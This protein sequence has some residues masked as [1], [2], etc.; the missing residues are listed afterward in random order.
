MPLFFFRFLASFYG[1]MKS[2]SSGFYFNWGM[3]YARWGQPTKAMYYLNRAAKLNS[4]GAQ[5]YYQRGLLFIAMGQPAAAIADFNTAIDTNPRYMEAYL[6]RSMMHTMTG[7]QNAALCFLLLA[8]AY[9]ASVEKKQWLAGLALGL[10]LFKP[11]YAVPVLGLL[12]LRKQFV[13]LGV[14]AVLGCGHYVIGALACGWDWP[15]K[16]ADKLGGYYRAAED[17]TNSATHM[18]FMEVLDYSVIQPLGRDGAVG[19]LLHLSGY[20]AL[21]L[22]VLYLIFVWRDAD[23]KREDFGLYWALVTSAALLLSLH[24]QY[25]DGALLL[26]PVLLILAVVSV[27]FRP[28]Q[29]MLPGFAGDVFGSGAVGL[30]WLASAMGVGATI[31]AVWIALRGRVGGLT[32]A[33]IA[34]F[35]LLSVATLG[36][37][38][39]PVLWIAVIFSALSGFALNT[40]STGTQALV[41]YAV[42]DSYRGRVMGLYTLIYRGT[43]AI[44]ALALGA[45]VAGAPVANAAAAP[46]RSPRARAWGRPS[47]GRRWNSSPVW[48]SRRAS[49][50]GCGAWWRR[51][52]ESPRCIS[53]IAWSRWRKATWRSS[54]SRI[55]TPRPSCPT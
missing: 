42:E 33:V 54:P 13:T 10:L 14:A 17:A 16:M 35:L 44:G 9:V 19:G 55:S 41:Q 18:S 38:A 24:T 20:V 21:A 6:N 47:S 48:V 15:A 23:P 51:A 36:L 52:R 8:V 39:T 27:L 53:A 12:L 49:A 3:T 5:I 29:D 43:P 2:V 37:V 22:F 30:A 50:R 28:V 11:Q 26:L 34:G 46:A 45:A 7:G 25:Y 31:S 1:G 40:M 4:T 32:M